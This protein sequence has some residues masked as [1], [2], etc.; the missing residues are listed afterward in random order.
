[1]KRRFAI[2]LFE[3][4]SATRANTSS[5]RR[6]SKDRGEVGG[7]EMTT[8]TDFASSSSEA[9]RTASATRADSGTP[10]SAARRGGKARYEAMNESRLPVRHAVTK[11]R[12]AERDAE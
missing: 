3:S 8:P 5:S 2:S 6:E 7:G 10:S 11:A 1:M 4:P 9:R 12:R